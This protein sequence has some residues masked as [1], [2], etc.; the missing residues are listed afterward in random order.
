MQQ[1]EPMLATMDP[2]DE[3]RKLVLSLFFLL[4]ASSCQRCFHPVHSS[5][6]NAILSSQGELRA[7]TVKQ[8]DAMKR[9]LAQGK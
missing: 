2:H 7:F 1:L 9:V 6:L 8:L 5:V 4:V 3:V